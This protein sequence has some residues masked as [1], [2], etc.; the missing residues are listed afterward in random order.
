MTHIPFDIIKIILTFITDDITLYRSRCV[1]RRWRDHI[2]SRPHRLLPLT[3]KVNYI[4]MSFHLDADLLFCII[5]DN[6]KTMVIKYNKIIQNPVV[7]IA[8]SK[9]IKFESLMYAL[10]KT[11]KVSKI[12]LDLRTKIVEHYYK[13]QFQCD[14]DIYGGILFWTEYKGEIDVKCKHKNYFVD[15]YL[16]NDSV[17]TYLL[18]IYKYKFDQRLLESIQ[19]YQLAPKIMDNTILQ[20]SRF[21]IQKDYSYKQ[22]KKLRRQGERCKQRQQNYN[23]KTK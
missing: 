11:C 23:N 1:C 12:I 13:Q 19:H 16:I 8:V 10:K 20:D 3:H 9:Y 14:R 22:S 2:N 4:P 15:L 6:G 5:T 7:V 18:P 17:V 21:M